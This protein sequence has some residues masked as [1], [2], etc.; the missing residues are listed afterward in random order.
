MPTLQQLRYLVAIADTGHFRRAAESC[1][2]TQPTLSVQLKQLEA[3]LN[4][5][6]VERAKN[7][8]HLTRFGEQIATHARAALNEVEEI[9]TL[10]LLQGGSLSSTIRV[11][12][13]H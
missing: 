8:A 10:S 12:V 13:V 6:L 11:G 2:V 5:T 9:R 1:N 4:A 7:R 3:K